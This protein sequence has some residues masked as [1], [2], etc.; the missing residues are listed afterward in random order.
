MRKCAHINLVPPPLA[1]EPL[2][3]TMYWNRTTEDDP[4]HRWL[5]DLLVEVA[6]QPD[7]RGPAD[8]DASCTLDG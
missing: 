2:L 6:A 8:R 4:A 1:I 3:E 7:L 5:R